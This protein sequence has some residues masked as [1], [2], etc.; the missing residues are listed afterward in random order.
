LKKKSNISIIDLHN[1]SSQN[2][3]FSI[4]N[5]TKE[6]KLAKYLN[7]PVINNLFSKVKGSLAS[8]YN[9]QNVNTIVFEGGAIGDPASINNHEAGIWKI[10]EKKQFI[11]ESEIPQRVIKN[12]N[13]MSI[14]AHNIKGNY[15]VIYIHKVKQEDD[16]LMNPNMYNFE[17]IEKN[18]IIAQDKNGIISSPKKGYLLMPLYQEKGNEGFYIIQHEKD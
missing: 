17:E 8:Y 15:K 3:V 5:N 9:S 2:G 11:Q 6:K 14:F 12:Y 7:I 4:V 10:L 1:T 13:N 18:Q 16:F